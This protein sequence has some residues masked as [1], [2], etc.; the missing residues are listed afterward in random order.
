MITFALISA[1]PIITTNSGRIFDNSIELYC[2]GK[3]YYEIA[4]SYDVQHSGPSPMPVF[5]SS[6]ALEFRGISRLMKTISPLNESSLSQLLLVTFQELYLPLFFSKVPSFSVRV[7][8]SI[9]LILKEVIKVTTKS[10]PHR[11]SIANVW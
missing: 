6:K 3:C 8:I 9:N 10:Q 4:T 2:F 5:P 11:S 1:I 7:K